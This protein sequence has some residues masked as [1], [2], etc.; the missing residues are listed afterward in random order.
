MARLVFTA[1][2]LSILYLVKVAINDLSV[3]DGLSDAIQA[4]L[5]AEPVPF[6]SLKPLDVLLTMLVRFFQSI[7]T[8]SD[9]ALTLFCIFLVGQLL[10]VHVVVQVEGLRAGNR[11]RLI[12]YTALW[13]LAW[14]LFTFGAMLP[15]YFLVYIYTSPISAKALGPDAF[16]A[17]ISVDP[18]QARAL[19]GSLAIGFVLPT[20]LVALPSPSVIAPHT[21]Q[22]A[23]AVWQGFPLWSGIAQAILSRLV[24]AGASGAVPKPGKHTAASGLADLRRIY[25][26]TLP[27]TG[28]IFYGVLGYVFWASE[29]ATD[30]ARETLRAVFVPPSPFSQAKMASVERGTLALLQW[31]MYC[32]ALATWSWI[33]YLSYQ[34]KGVGRAVMDLGRLLVWSAV[35]GPGGA[36]LAVVWGR[37]VEFMQGVG[38]G[39]RKTG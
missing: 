11:G 31:D 18:A 17:A 20:L 33:A 39:K 23:V 5:R 14:Q 15:V 28:L 3:A 22:I 6:T 9:P 32:A 10:A 35:V 21:Q 4:Q 34:T 27:A 30:P 12:S 2:F 36:A 37:D 24:G 7:L 16:A 29:W 26:L 8:G 1:V 13:G 19:P 38:G 25:A